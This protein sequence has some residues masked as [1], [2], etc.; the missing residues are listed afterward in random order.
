[1]FA[2][3]ATQSFLTMQYIVVKT[4]PLYKVGHGP[5]DFLNCVNTME[6]RMKKM[7]MK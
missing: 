4:S 2:L 5:T 3:K 6:R 7:M 1:M